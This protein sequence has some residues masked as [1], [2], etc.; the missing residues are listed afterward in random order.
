M[1]VS[2]KTEPTSHLNSFTSRRPHITMQGVKTSAFSVESLIS[3]ESFTEPKMEGSHGSISLP[4]CSSV[5][6]E[7]TRTSPSFSSTISIPRPLALDGVGSGHAS[8]FSQTSQLPLSSG[9]AFTIQRNTEHHSGT[10]TSTTLNF[11]FQFFNCF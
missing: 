6:Q 4:R 7:I 2:F 10:V 9:R 11:S 1:W 3:K 5:G 8:A